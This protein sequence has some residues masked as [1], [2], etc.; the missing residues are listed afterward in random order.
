ML[1]NSDRTK[2]PPPSVKKKEKKQEKKRTPTQRRP[3]FLPSFTGFDFCWSV[4]FFVFSLVLFCGVGGV[5][6]VVVVVG[7]VVVGVVGV[8]L[9]VGSGD[10]NRTFLK[11]EP[12]CL[13]ALR[14]WP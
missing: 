9:A 2:A 12:D 13:T 4:S 5:V 14:W 7:V 1:G 3:L 11:A 10:G 6:V 8:G